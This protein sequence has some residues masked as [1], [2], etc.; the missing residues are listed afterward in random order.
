MT[1]EIVD[2]RI[3]NIIIINELNIK[4]LSPLRKYNDQKHRS[5][6]ITIAYLIGNYFILHQNRLILLHQQTFHSVL[7]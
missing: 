6:S 7:I 1:S 5:R 2:Y 4:N 3:Y